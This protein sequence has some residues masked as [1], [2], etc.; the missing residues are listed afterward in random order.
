[1]RQIPIQIPTGITL[2]AVCDVYYGE[3]TIHKV[4]SPTERKVS[5]KAIARHTG[6]SVDHVIDCINEAVQ[7]QLDAELENAP[8]ERADI[9]DDYF[10]H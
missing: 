5:Y 3:A 1:M 9:L 2:I 7:D 4:L 8:Y 6:L 10:A